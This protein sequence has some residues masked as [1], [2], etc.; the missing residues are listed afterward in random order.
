M[1]T[2]LEAYIRTCG[3]DIEDASICS[4]I[5]DYLSQMEDAE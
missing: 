2:E 4:A 1:R 5:D 3:E